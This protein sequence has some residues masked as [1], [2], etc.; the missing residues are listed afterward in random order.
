MKANV[1]SSV[2]KDSFNSGVEVANNALKGIKNP[3]LGFLFTSKDKKVEEVVKGIKSVNQNIKI[4]GFNTDSVLT[5]E[6]IITSD[7]G[8]SSML[9][10][11]DNELSVGISSINKTNNPREMGREVARNAMINANKKHNPVAYALFTTTTHEED[12]IKGVQDIV[13]E[14]PMFGGSS[15]TDVVYTEEDVKNG[16]AI[17]LFYTTKDIINLF[18]NNYNQ[19]NKIGIITE[20]ENDSTIVSIDNEPALEKYSKWLDKPFKD[21]NEVSILSPLGINQNELTII[22]QP[23]A[24]NNKTITMGTKVIENTAIVMLENNKDGLIKGA[25]DTLKEFP[26]TSAAYLLLHSNGRKL[27][28]NDDIDELFVAIQNTCKDIPF[29]VP[30]TNSEFGQ[31]N[32]SGTKVSN[33]SLSFTSFSK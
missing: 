32:H 22:S 8:F 7:N 15:L 1:G 6:G 14:L 2:L 17:V 33:L 10:L 27:A 30:F 12:Y 3:K 31:V 24:N 21:I 20:V 19:T 25:L 13:G 23:V 4:I 26:N 11:D 28:I 18:A 5:N 9:V 16:L 29:I